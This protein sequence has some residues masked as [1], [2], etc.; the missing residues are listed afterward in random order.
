MTTAAEY[1]KNKPQTEYEF[2]AWSGMTFTLRRPGPS[3]SIDIMETIKPPENAD[4]MTTEEKTAYGLS[5]MEDRDILYP[6]VLP[7]YVISPPI[8]DPGI[9]GSK[10]KLTLEEIHE[11]DKFGILN[12]LMTESAGGRGSQRGKAFPEKRQGA[13][14]G[15]D[16][17]SDKPEGDGDNPAE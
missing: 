2:E 15:P 4:K 6:V 13:T 14:D 12:S 10:K 3:M 16:G 7:K 11:E 8:Q 5:V 9:V 1:R 17:V